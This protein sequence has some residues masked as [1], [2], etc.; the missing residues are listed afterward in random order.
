MLTKRKCRIRPGEDRQRWDGLKETAVGAKPVPSED[1]P[2]PEPTYEDAALHTLHYI[3]GANTLDISF[4][5]GAGTD[6]VRHHRRTHRKTRR[7]EEY[8]RIQGRS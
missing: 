3:L 7:T 8:R 2:Q 5:A 1:M 6:Y 4:V